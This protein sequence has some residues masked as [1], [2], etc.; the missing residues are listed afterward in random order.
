MLGA[1]WA[2]T[3]GML[4]MGAVLLTACPSSPPADRPEP[5][6]ILDVGLNREFSEI[7]SVE[8]TFGGIYLSVEQDVVLLGTRASAEASVR[9]AT[10]TLLAERQLSDR[11]TEFQLCAYSW[12][13]LMATADLAIRSCA[14]EHVGSADVDE[15]Q[16]RVVLGAYPSHEQAL[17]DCLDLAGVDVSKIVIVEHRKGGVR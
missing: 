8:A 5:E 1:R 13:E 3:A 9:E 12:L 14:A 10:R 4:G 17:R 15:M 7:G 16:N 2:R 6:L 11:R